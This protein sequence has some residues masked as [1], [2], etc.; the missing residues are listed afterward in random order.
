MAANDGWMWQGR[1]YHQWFG[2]GTKPKDEKP[3]DPLPDL[4]GRIATLPLTAV[5]GLPRSKRAHHAARFEGERAAN[6]VQAMGVW[7]R[8]RHLPL[9]VFA[10][11]FFDG[12]AETPGVKYLHAAANAVGDAT[13]FADM[14]QATDHVAAAMME[15]GLDWFHAYVQQAAGVALV[16]G[17]PAPVRQPAVI[18][19]RA[20]EAPLRQVPGSAPVA[21]ARGPLGWLAAL[22]E[23]LRH[24]DASRSA[25]AVQSAI[26]RFGLDARNPNDAA[27]A[28][29]YVWATSFGSVQFGADWSG[30]GL[31]EMA[32]A[33]MEA[34]RADP[35]L[36][37]RA[38]KG[39]PAAL[40]KLREAVAAAAAPGAGIETYNDEERALVASLVAAGKDNREISAALDTL[41]KRNPEKTRA[42]VLR[43]RMANTPWIPRDVLEKIPIEWGLGKPNKDGIGWR[44]EN[45][46]N[47]GDGVRIDQAV[48]GSNHATQRVDHVIIR[49][50]GTVRDQNG[51]PLPGSIETFPLKAH[52]PLRIYRSWQSWNKP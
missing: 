12:H 46:S 28:R 6:F 7:A 16:R 26:E 47:K 33:V 19:A 32:Q 52:I 23:S 31:E 44:W 41:R 25:D 50:G 9:D 36:L 13:S 14:R 8:A 5:A 43:L 37:D 29:A 27:A 15:V 49:T 1:Q 22:A 4:D 11:R 35:A 3:R 17:A 40:A 42:D 2:H 39:D 21:P 48:P 38:S 45:P 30:P 20:P 51:T 18:L 10:S 34:V 24:W